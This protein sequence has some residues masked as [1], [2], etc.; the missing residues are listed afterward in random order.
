MNEHHLNIY[1][2]WNG[3]LVVGDDVDGAV[4]RVVGQLSHVE[5]L[6]DNTLEKRSNY[7]PYS[8]FHLMFHSFIFSDTFKNM[9]F[10]IDQ[11][12]K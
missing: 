4:G 3:N 7:L 11:T 9:K 6:V 12:Q 8:R 5:R 10:R 1:N 2:N